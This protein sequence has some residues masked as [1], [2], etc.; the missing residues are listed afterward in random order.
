VLAE[1]QSENF[2]RRDRFAL[3]TTIG[4]EYGTSVATLRLIRDRIREML[5]AHPKLWEGQAGVHFVNFGGSSLD[6]EI[7]CWL[8]VEDMNEFKAV[9]EEI[10][11]QVMEIVEGNGASF[12]FPTQTVHLKR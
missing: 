9:R 2:G 6:V 11:L 8:S 4:V 10:F 12:A 3:H 1:S 5:L 7:L